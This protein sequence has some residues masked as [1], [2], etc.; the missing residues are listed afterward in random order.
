MSRP[1]PE[2]AR[3]KLCARAVNGDGRGAPVQAVCPSRR[4][5][6]INLMVLNRFFWNTIFPQTWALQTYAPAR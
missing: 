1:P 4:T 5:R 2:G 6:S 3:K